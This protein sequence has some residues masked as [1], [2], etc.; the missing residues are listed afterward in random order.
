MKTMTVLLSV[1]AAGA[2]TTAS[3]VPKLATPFA[4]GSVF[5]EVNLPLGTFHI[6]LCGIRPSRVK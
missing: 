6:G 1:C 3:A 2:M 4:D 5:N